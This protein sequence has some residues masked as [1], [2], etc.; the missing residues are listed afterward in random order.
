[1]RPKLVDQ[2]GR[3]TVAR[4]P[5]DYTAARILQHSLAGAHSHSAGLGVLLVR[6]A[7]PHNMP[8]LELAQLAPQQQQQ[9]TD[10]TLAVGMPA[11]AD[12][13][14]ACML[15]SETWQ[16]PLEIYSDLMLGS[17]FRLNRVE[18]TTANTMGIARFTCEYM[19]I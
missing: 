19:L 12:A 13:K 5:A 15:K 2:V 17:A 3:H 9:L 4:R 16:V 8:L 18:T 7:V 11:P 6:T 1:M 14:S 10:R